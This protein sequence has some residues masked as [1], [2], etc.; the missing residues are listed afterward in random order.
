MA[1]REVAAAMGVSRQRASELVTAAAR[2]LR[3]ALDRAA[4][5]GAPELRALLDEVAP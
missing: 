2:R 1:P 5:G 3:A 4:A